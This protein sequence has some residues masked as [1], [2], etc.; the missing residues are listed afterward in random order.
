MVSR[1]KGGMQNWER[2]NMKCVC[3][4]LRVNNARDRAMTRTMR[5]KLR[6]F[7]EFFQNGLTRRIGSETT[8]RVS[9]VFGAA[10]V[11]TQWRGRIVAARGNR[12]G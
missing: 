1:D 2:L 9:L 7:Q 3:V 11:A 5:P 4:K 8:E 6:L 10:L 12:R